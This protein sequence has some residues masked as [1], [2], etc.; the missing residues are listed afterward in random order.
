MLIE[1]FVTV[2]FITSVLIIIK[3]I[4]VFL[5]VVTVASTSFE[6]KIALLPIT[7]ETWCL[8]QKNV[9]IC[10]LRFYIGT[11]SKEINLGLFIDIFA[12]YAPVLIFIS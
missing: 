2:L 10:I 6:N 3:I 8:F 1:M 9:N 5:S 7:I 4:R 11:N 12:N